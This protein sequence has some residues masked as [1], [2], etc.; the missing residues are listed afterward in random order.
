MILTF[1]IFFL[2]ASMWDI[3]HAN[4]VLNG[5]IN[6]GHTQQTYHE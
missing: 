2:V 6:P 3:T 1:L 5:M 4:K